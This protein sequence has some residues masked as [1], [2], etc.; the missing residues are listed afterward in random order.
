MQSVQKRTVA[1]HQK[2]NV[3]KL[4][5]EN[6]LVYVTAKDDDLL[7]VTRLLERCHLPY[8]D[9]SIPLDYFV[10][11][12]SGGL[13]VGSIGLELYRDHGLL[14]S[15]AVD[16]QYRN[17]K[18]GDTLVKELIAMSKDK[19]VKHL[20]LLTTTAQQYFEKHAFETVDREHVPPEIKGSTQFSALCPYTAICMYRNIS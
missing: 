6:T 2:P 20:Y 19:G 15:L 3:A 4:G 1:V 17:N 9:L 11:A 12:K 5:M 8:G 16:D 10:V 7:A 18:I 14:R 13:L